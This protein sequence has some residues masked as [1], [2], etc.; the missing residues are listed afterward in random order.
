M[1]YRAISDL[2]DFSRDVAIVVDFIGKDEYRESLFSIGRSLNAKGFVTPYDDEAFALELDLLNLEFLRAHTGGNFQSL[3]ETCHEGVNFLIGLGQTIP[4]LSAEA[5][6]RLLGRIR[7]GLKEG[8]WPLQHELRVA[9]LLSKLGWDIYFHDLEEDGGYDF[10][11]TQNGVAFEVEAKAV[12]LYTAWPMKPEDI[13]KLLV[14]VKQR[15]SWEDEN[16]IP[17][18]SLK[19]SSGLSAEQTQLRE[20]VSALTEVAR[21]GEEIFLPGVKIRSIGTVSNMPANNLLM[22]S[23]IHHMM[24]KK[25]V[26]VNAASP[27]LVLELDS[28]KPIRL[29]KKMLRAI[30]ETAKEQLSR[31]NPGVIW[32][33]ISM[34]HNDAFTAFSSSHNG[35]AGVLDRIASAV[36]LSEK[37]NHLSQL[38]F[39]GGSMLKKTPS[40]AYSSS[41]SAI[42][43]SPH[44]RFGS[45][46]IIPGGRKWPGRKKELVKALRRA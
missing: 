38:V 22:A 1:R 19:F 18:L 16:R 11:A 27:K 25:I 8:L 29:A 9:A 20:L 44:C 12:S 41:E 36:L 43:D 26:V 40:V 24:A 10:F 15:F 4:H 46:V 2:S 3:P 31:S 35:E 32:M 28:N 45:N 21:T 14:E 30:R 34:V 17:I 6:T 33:H 13:N 23:K 37:R 5:R 39:T 42:Y 7:K